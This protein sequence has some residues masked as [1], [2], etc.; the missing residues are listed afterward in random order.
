MPAANAAVCKRTLD[1]PNL[2]CPLGGILGPLDFLLCNVN[3]LLSGLLLFCGS[4][5]ILDLTIRVTAG[6]Y[7]LSLTSTNLHALS[8]TTTGNGNVILNVNADLNIVT[9]LVVSGLGVL[10]VPVGMVVN[11]L[12]N[13]VV[14]TGSTLRVAGN[15][16]VTNTTNIF[17]TLQLNGTR[18]QGTSQSAW[19]STNLLYFN[20]GSPLTPATMKGNGG[21]IGNVVCGSNVK[22]DIG[23][24]PGVVYIDGNFQLSS[25]TNMIIEVESAFS[26]DAF[27][28]TRTFTR[29][30]GKATLNFVGYTP[31]TSDRFIFV[32]HADASGFFSNVTGNHNS[33][34]ATF[35]GRS[36]SVIY[37]DVHQPSYCSSTCTPVPD[38]E[39]YR[40]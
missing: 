6:N 24:S 36:T 1:F 30:S 22:L 32:T 13:L 17:G 15:L 12:G 33:L 23:N 19:L 7:I 28:V 26:F 20:N 25:T 9:N 10:L 34:S 5:P 39:E 3:S 35:G 11:V 40:R 14:Q 37:D 8:I 4:N 21:I 38:A 31:N 2:S 29:G 27:A 18:A 16:T